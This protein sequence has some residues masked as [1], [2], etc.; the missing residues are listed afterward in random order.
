[1]INYSR[2]HVSNH[3]LIS[4]PNYSGKYARNLKSPNFYLTWGFQAGSFAPRLEAGSTFGEPGVCETVEGA[5]RRKPGWSATEGGEEVAELRR[6][7]CGEGS[8]CWIE[9]SGR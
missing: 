9:M 5:A 1:M 6:R 3:K 4:L 8:R 2:I 7:G